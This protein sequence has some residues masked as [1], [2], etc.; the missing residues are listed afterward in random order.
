MT[1]LAWN[2]T[3]PPK[4]LRAH[5]KNI[6]I[7]GDE[8]PDADLIQSIR[9]KGILEPLVIR[10]DKTI[11]SGH[12]RW[13]AA[14]ALNLDTVP[15]R[16]LTFS[17][18]DDEEE[19]LIE[20]NRQRK[21]TPHQTLNEVEHLTRIYAERAKVNQEATRAKPGEQAHLRALEN[22]PKPINTREDVAAKVGVSS[23]TI[24]KWDQIKKKAEVNDKAK[25]VW[26]AVNRGERSTNSAFNEIRKIEKQELIQ[27]R[28]VMEIDKK[29]K[30]RVVYAD[31]PWSYGGSMNNTYGTADTHYPTMTVDEICGVCVRDICEDDAVLFLWT[32]SPCLEDAF[33][34]INAWGF[35]YK[36]SFVWDKQKH[37]MGHY[38]SV[39]HEF[40]LVSTRGS[41]T[42][43][44][45]K[46]YPSVVSIERTEHSKKPPSFRE[47]IDDLYPSGN[48]IEL[49]ARDQYV[50]WDVYGNQL[51]M[52]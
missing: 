45:K 27:T 30:Y 52:V 19:A 5:P 8:I 39:R 6:E 4:E 44:N 32:T 12:R 10:D 22:S 21:K 9:S 40:L 24:R 38:N 49:F 46:L 43:E 29:K 15:C 17:D 51:Y 34:V 25:E 16:I 13:A 1:G 31:P 35:R 33:R 50:G 42:P 36:A 2:V 26:A 14:V 7:Y 20:F 41:C 28:P 47:M 37:V 11:L 23:D 48:R 18:R 3:H